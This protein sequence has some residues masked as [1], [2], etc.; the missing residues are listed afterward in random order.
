[1]VAVRPRGVQPAATVAAE[2]ASG[3]SPFMNRPR[4]EPPNLRLL[5]SFAVPM[6]LSQASETVM[7]FVDRLFLAQ[8]GKV[9]IAASMSGGL[10]AFVFSSLFAG[11]VGYTNALTA[12]YYGAD[13]EERCVHVITQGIYLSL[14]FAPL[15][16]ALIP[17]V[18][19][20]FR[21]AGHTPEQI[22]L[23]H[24]YFSILMSAGLFILLRQAL[25][26]FFLGIGLTKVVMVANLVGMAVNVPLNYVLIFGKLGLPALGIR[27]AA[28]GTIGGSLLIVTILFVAYTR[29]R[30]YNSVSRRETW[31]LRKELL[32][33][34][35]RYGGPAGTE[36][37]LNVFAFNVFVQLF[38]S[39]GPDVAA[40]VTITFNYDML[41]FIPMVGLGVAVTAMV[42]QQMGA[43]N[44]DG[45]HRATMLALRVGYTYA[46]VMM[47]L[48]VFGAGA[49]VRAFAGGLAPGEER[50]LELSKAMLR[51][52]AIYTLADI[53]Q[54][55]FAGALRGAGDTRWVMYISVVLHWIMA[56]AAV[57]LIRVFALPPL[58]IWLFFIGFVILLGVSIF[59]RYGSGKW[60][61]LQIIDEEKIEAEIHAP[62]IQ[63]ESQWI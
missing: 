28:Y 4:V 16:I 41:A 29:H 21:L 26:G 22:V 19:F 20:T 37:F 23:E 24:T 57:L 7:L 36:L 59:A 35:L 58:S 1:M 45:A 25:V 49:L 56:V 30:F 17:L 9:H 38:H 11:I 8:L 18:G 6:I 12:Q 2:A 60:K 48:F 34:L 53:T 63:T 61:S 40:A 13:R 52:A 46:F 15:L 10:S 51:L 14:F 62:E 32:L 39:M 33:R 31:R 44:P 54:L 47:L 5:L 42:G 43:R 3:Y 50:L 55:V 27:G